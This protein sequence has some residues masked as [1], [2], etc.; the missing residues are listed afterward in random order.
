MNRTTEWQLTLGLLAVTAM[1][2]A[3]HA[4]PASPAGDVNFTIHVHNYA[5]VDGKTLAQAEKV[6][7]RIFER[8]GVVSQWTDAPLQEQ[9]YTAD[10]QL[11]GLSHIWVNIMPAAMFDSLAP[12]AAGLA[13]GVGPDRV[14]AYIFY[15]RVEE[16]RQKQLAAFLRRDVESPTTV[17]GLLGSA[18]AHEIGHILLNLAVHSK[19]GIMRGNWDLAVLSDIGR[20]RLYFTNDQETIMRA[21][22]A[23]RAR[24]QQVLTAAAASDAH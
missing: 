12:G 13:P 9:E 1:A 22:V 23:R 5:G 17:E 6:T 15:N 3:A 8:A 7:S 11:A 21:E 20:G 19:T 4:S 10:P 14:L 2:G 24:T 18:M 16:M